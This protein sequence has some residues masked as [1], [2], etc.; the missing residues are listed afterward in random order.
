MSVMIG[1]ASGPAAIRMAAEDLAAECGDLC[2]RLKIGGNL[3]AIYD[4]TVAE[5]VPPE[6]Q[7]QLDALDR[8]RRLRSKKAAR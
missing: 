1:P 7:R 2:C 6:M 8:P 3:R 4:S 5:G